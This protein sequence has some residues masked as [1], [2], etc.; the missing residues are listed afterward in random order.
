VFSLSISS[1]LF[2]FEHVLG[3]LRELRLRGEG[4][5][6][7]G[8]GCADLNGHFGS[9]RAWPGRPA[10]SQGTGLQCVRDVG[11]SSG[12]SKGRRDGAPRNAA[13]GAMAAPCSESLSQSLISAAQSC[14]SGGGTSALFCRDCIFSLRC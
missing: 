4:Q 2:R 13:A 9:S 3:D 7:A 1:N 8:D 11:P 14:V 12:Q 6:K 5:R 10:S